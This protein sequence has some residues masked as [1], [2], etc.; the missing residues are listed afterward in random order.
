[1]KCEK[2]YEYHA[3]IQISLTVKEGESKEEA[4]RRMIDILYKTDIGFT[5]VD[6]D[7]IAECSI[8]SWR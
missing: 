4:R 5:C 6:D 2:C 1:M 7:Y 8:I 3:Q